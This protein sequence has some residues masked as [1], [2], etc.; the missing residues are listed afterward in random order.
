M[1]RI[2]PV[3]SLGLWRLKDFPFVGSGLSIPKLKTQQNLKTVNPVNPIN[4]INPIN[5]MS[6]VNTPKPS[7]P[8]KPYLPLLNPL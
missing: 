3:W 1:P 8:S 7:Q 5:S 2:L 6:A 4:S